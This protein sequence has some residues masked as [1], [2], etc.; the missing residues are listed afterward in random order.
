MIEQNTWQCDMKCWKEFCQDQYRCCLL[1]LHVG[2]AKCFAIYVE[3]GSECALECLEATEEEA[4]LHLRLLWEGEL[5]PCH[6][7]DYLD[8]LRVERR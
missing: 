4:E 8:D 7:R 3:Q 1:K 5:S 2:K 6:L